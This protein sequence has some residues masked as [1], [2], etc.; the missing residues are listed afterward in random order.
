[1]DSF[2]RLFPVWVLLASLLNFLFPFLLDWMTSSH[3]SFLLSLIML[4][5]GITLEKEDFLRIKRMPFV[6]LA[7]VILQYTIM[8]F[9]GFSL[10]QILNLPPALSYG[11]ILVSC[12]PGGTASNVICYLAKADVALSVTLT[13]ISTLLAVVLT[14]YLSYL[15][16]GSRVDVNAWGLFLSTLQVIVIPVIL[17]LFLKNYLP[18]TTAKILPFAPPI[19]VISI[20]LIVSSVIGKGKASFLSAGVELFTAVILL[21]GLGFL[22]GYLISVLLFKNQRVA[23]TISIEVGMQNSGLGVVLAKLHF[24]DPMTALPAALSSLC[25]SLMG[26]SLASVWARKK[27]KN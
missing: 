7:G 20:V 6:V 9:L 17:G 12:C 14:P 11:V 5:M 8:P 15:L 16:M 22:M 3:I 23:R 25:H 26:S 2:T 4:G 18:K 10:A 21:H 1:M 19:A 13:T 27:A 24:A